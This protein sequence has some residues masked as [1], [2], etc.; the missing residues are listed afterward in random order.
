LIQSAGGWIVAE[1]SVAE[2]ASGDGLIVA[3]FSEA[4]RGFVVDIS[5]QRSK[6]SLFGELEYEVE[7]AL[8]GVPAEAAVATS[9]TPNGVRTY[10]AQNREDLFIEAFFPDVAEGFY[11]DIGASDPVVDSVTKLFYDRGWHGINVEPIRER[12]LTLQADRPRDLN[13]NAGV[14]GKSGSMTFHEY[15]NADGRSTFSP[16]LASD[17]ETEADFDTR[18]ATAYEVP[19]TTLAD[20]IKDNDVPHIHFLK[21]DVEGFEYEVIEGYDWQGVRPELLCI[22]ADRISAERDWRPLIAQRGYELVFHDGLN[23]YYL[24]S[25]AMDRAQHFNY[26][27]VALN[28]TSLR[29]D[30]AMFFQ[31]KEGELERSVAI[32]QSLTAELADLRDELARTASQV[33]W[34]HRE[35]AARDADVTHLAGQVEWLHR[36]VAIRDEAAVE[37]EALIEQLRATPGWRRLRDA[38]QGAGRAVRRA[39]RR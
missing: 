32:V 19:V 6:D 22:E 30:V 12:W 28:T 16:E 25:E 20:V 7:S 27:D 39:I 38:T 33:A 31:T 18:G 5:Y 8:T 29:H 10:F 3:S 36:E 15:P 9:G 17:Y 34:L 23:N 26:A 11:V 2:S 37:R 24:A 4:D 35:V 14:A 21:I 1:H 13:I